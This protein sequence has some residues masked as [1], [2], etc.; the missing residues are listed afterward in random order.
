M[1]TPG[2]WSQSAGRCPATATTARCGRLSGTTD[3]GGR[4]TVIADGGYQ[5]TGLVIPDSRERGQ[6]EL[7]AWKEEHN[8]SHRK[9]RARIEH[10]FARIRAGRSSATVA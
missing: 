7:P 1:P 4:T 2:S 3:A 6:V 9:V 10:A 8:A 5:G